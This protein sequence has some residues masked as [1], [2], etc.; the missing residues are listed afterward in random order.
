MLQTDN[1]N[2]NNKRKMQKQEYVKNTRG[3]TSVIDEILECFYDNI[4]GVPLSRVNDEQCERRL[5]SH[6]P[7]LTQ[8]RSNHSS[9]LRSLFR[10]ASSDNLNRASRE[11][12]DPYALI[13]HGNQASVRPNLKDVME[14]EDIYDYTASG[15]KLHSTALNR[16]FMKSSVIQIISPRS[17][18][19]AFRAPSGIENPHGSLPGL[20]AVRVAKV[21]ILWR[22]APK[23]KRGRSPWQPWG[24]LLTDSKFYLFRDAAWT[25]SLIAQQQRQTSKPAGGGSSRQQQQPHKG[26][27]VFQPPLTEFKPDA[28]IPTENAV[29]LVDSTYRKHKHAFFFVGAGVPGEI[30]LATTEEE[31]NEWMGMLN[32]AAAFKST[33]VTMRGSMGAQFESLA[34]EQ[35]TTSGNDSVASTAEIPPL[36]TASEPA[37]LSTTMSGATTDI[38][39][40]NNSNEQT[41]ESTLA[42]E[43]S[44]ARRE[45]LALRIAETTEKI[46]NMEPNLNHQ[47]RNAHHLQIIV[48][49]QNRTREDIIVAAGRLS[50]K[51]KWA[52]VDMW[53]WKCYRDTLATEL[54][55]EERY[56]RRQAFAQKDPS[57]S[58]VGDESFKT[59]SSGLSRQS[60]VEAD[61]EGKGEL[62]TM[63][64]REETGS[65]TTPGGPP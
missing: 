25:E 35:Q 9:P 42:T 46:T 43:V 7:S 60:D 51:I 20:V 55:D 8:S 45:L 40:N 54:H 38:D 11:H 16:A 3:Q 47:L 24:A 23:K 27:V 31:R 19:D 41:V 14:L 33:G 10:V 12:L 56:A 18:P 65:P 13:L 22:K 2:K 58:S 4:T 28:V 52:R 59:A 64:D 50:A 26:H 53:R 32:H 6:P 21:G 1:T 39:D 5:R 37:E 17:R 57:S 63:G 36:T 61:V 34:I 30:F 15:Y 49:L 29:A 44:A 62:Q 48:P